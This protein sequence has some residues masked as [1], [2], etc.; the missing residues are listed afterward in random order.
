MEI[1]L[2]AGAAL[3]LLIAVFGAWHGVQAFRFASRLQH[4]ARKVLQLSAWNMFEPLISSLIAFP[5]GMWGIAW[6]FNCGMNGTRGRNQILMGLIFLV[7]F[8]S[9]VTFLLLP[10]LLPRSPML[11]PW[12]SMKSRVVM[13]GLMRFA[14]I[15]LVAIGF[16]LP[17]INYLVVTAGF[18][19][20]IY[21]LLEVNKIVRSVKTQIFMS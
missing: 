20:L 7:P 14:S 21:S 11:E 10:V 17:Y 5:F 8:I 1:F 16:F 9:P 4:E 19:F 18:A 15:I 13:F 3:L 6:S 2:F 12:Q